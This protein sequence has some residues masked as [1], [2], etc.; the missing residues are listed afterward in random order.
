MSPKSAKGIIR[1][2]ARAVKAL[3]V[4]AIAVRGVSGLTVGAPVAFLLGLPLMI[5]RK[6]HELAHCHSTYNVE[7]TNEK[8]E[9]YASYCI[10]DDFISTGRTINEIVHV[11]TTA[12][13]IPPLVVKGALK[14]IVLYNSIKGRD[15]W[16][17]SDKKVAVVE[18]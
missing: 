13:P 18:I 5:V 8:S 12:R 4:E 6:S 14:A 1:R 11:I 3:G 17:V 10:I 7:T 15:Y 9:P 2:T 16:L